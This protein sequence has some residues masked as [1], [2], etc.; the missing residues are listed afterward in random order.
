MNCGSCF[1]F[2]FGPVRSRTWAT[3]GRILLL[4]LRSKLYGCYL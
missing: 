2:A 1:S 3:L 4:N